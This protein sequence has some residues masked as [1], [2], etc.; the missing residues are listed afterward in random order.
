MQTK[1]LCL[2]LA[3]LALAAP[4]ALAQQGNLQ[5]LVPPSV[6]LAGQKTRDISLGYSSLG[7]ARVNAGCLDLNAVFAARGPGVYAGGSIGTA[8]VG[9]VGPERLY[10]GAVGKDINGVTF[11][12]NAFMYR[13]YGGGEY[14]RRM[15]L[16]S[17]PLSFGSFTIGSNNNEEIK[18]YNL[19]AGLQG[20]GAL[21]F[22]AGDFMLTPAAMGAV[23]GGYREKYKGGVYYS[24]LN[25]GGVRPFFV[26]TLAAD[27]L[28]IPRHFKVS[29]AWQRS[30]SS[31]VDRA[32]DAAMLQVAFGW[33]GW[34]R[35]K[36]AGGKNAE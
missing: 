23:M 32:V 34:G 20:G 4:A 18:I 25:S 13:L 15:L 22:K 10:L 24:N 12:A 7:G 19:L 28:Y 29:T 11:H 33:E 31:G 14:P 5:V 30:F 6:D 36:A 16:A 35:R 21:N 8:L 17:V 27:L 26:L 3:A 1:G 9:G 2:A